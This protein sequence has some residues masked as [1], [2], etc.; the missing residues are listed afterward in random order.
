MQ[1]ATQLRRTCRK[2]RHSQPTLIPRLRSLSSLRLDLR[3][4]CL[5]KLE[6][7]NTG[8]SSGG[9]GQLV[10]DFASSGLT[11]TGDAWDQI[12]IFG[13]RTSYKFRGTSGL[14]AFTGGNNFQF[15]TL[16]WWMGQVGDWDIVT[17]NFG[18]GSGENGT[19]NG[20]VD[21]LKMTVGNNDLSTNFEAV[22]EPFTMASLGLAWLAARR[23][24]KKPPKRQHQ[25]NRRRR[26]TG[27][28]G[29]FV[30]VAAC[31]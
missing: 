1:T 25:Q 13:N 5:V 7:Q 10:F 19:F 29:V 24:K 30:I 4:Q 12:D 2:P 14:G 9:Y 21:N 8:L 22:P 28:S 20:A 16:D 18:I 17:V 23:K 15:E 27:K 6:L 11:P 3:W 31:K 26:Q